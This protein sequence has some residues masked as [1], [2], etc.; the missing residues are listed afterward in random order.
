MKKA[1]VSSTLLVLLAACGSS[2]LDTI[3]FEGARFTGDYRVDRSDRAAFVARGGPASVSLDGARQAAK[4]QAVQHCISYLGTSDVAWV[5]G[6]D[7]ADAA[8]VVEDN[9]VVLSGRCREP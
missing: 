1:W 8:L 3:T 7:V 2:D 9:E 5:N 6:P 4:F